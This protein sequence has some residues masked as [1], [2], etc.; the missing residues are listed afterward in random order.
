MG[1]HSTFTEELGAEICERLSHGETQA[2]ICRDLKIGY[3]T[4][5]DWMAAHESFAVEVARARDSGYEAIA[6][7]CFKIA[8][9]G[10]NDTYEDEN[11]NQ[12]SAPDVVQR[13]KLRVE[14][15]LKLL[16][17]WSPKRYGNKISQE[18]TGPN[19]GPVQIQ[20]I[21]RVIVDAE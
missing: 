13:S 2:S 1:I 20:E 8:D 12:R 18:H 7:D 6:D 9:D 11:G 5:Y 10:I 19:G 16:A 15:R 4:V 17:C 14:T 21:R 3:Q